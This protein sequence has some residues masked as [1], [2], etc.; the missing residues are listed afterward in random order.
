M[1]VNFI[2]CLKYPSEIKHHVIYGS[3]MFEFSGRLKNVVS[4]G[5]LKQFMVKVRVK[6]N[7]VLTT[8]SA[9]RLNSCLSF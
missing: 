9:I 5:F 8:Q 4:A 1:H 6:T 3:Y 7:N 2:N